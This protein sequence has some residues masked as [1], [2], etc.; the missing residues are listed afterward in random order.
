MSKTYSQQLTL[1]LSLLLVLCLTLAALPSREGSPRIPH[2]VGAA[3]ITKPFVVGLMI[4]VQD[5]SDGQ[6]D[7]IKKTGVID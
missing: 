1:L 2:I 3:R 4:C 5:L 6:R 7:L